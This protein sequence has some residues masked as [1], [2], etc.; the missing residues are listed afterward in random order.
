MYVLYILLLRISLW[1]WV[2]LE[3]SYATNYKVSKME[4]LWMRYCV[5][6]WVIW[7]IKKLKNGSSVENGGTFIGFSVFSLLVYFR[8]WWH[9]FNKSSINS[10]YMF[11]RI[12]NRVNNSKFTYFVHIWLGSKRLF[13]LVAIFSW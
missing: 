1:A 12:S 5:S 13:I 3:K 2:I 11:I 9:L 7:N 6:K 10:F 4:F 8:N